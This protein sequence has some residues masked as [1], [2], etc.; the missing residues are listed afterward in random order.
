MPTF[1]C[2]DTG[3]KCN[4]EVKDDNQEELLSIINLHAETTH[5]VKEPSMWEKFKKVIKK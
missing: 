3:M 2:K 5:S 4:F 1:K